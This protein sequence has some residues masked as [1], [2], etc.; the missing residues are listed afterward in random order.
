MDKDR[1]SS[2]PT[3]SPFR[4]RLTGKL[5]AIVGIVVIAPIIFFVSDS[6]PS[7]MGFDAPALRQIEQCPLAV[8][9]LGAP[10]SRS[11]LGFSCGN[12]KEN[13]SSGH[14]NWTFPVTGPRGHGSLDVSAVQ[15]GGSWTLRRAMLETDRGTIDVL[16]CSGGGPLNVQPARFHARVTSTLG[17]PQVAVGDSCDVSIEAAP[18]GGVQNCRVR[19]DCGG[20]FLYGSGTSGYARCNAD[21]SGAVVARDDQPTSSGGDPTLDLQVARHEAIVTDQTSSGTWVVQ[22]SLEDAQP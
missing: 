19:I 17:Q 18:P 22:L 7:C 14:A 8:E 3:A 9:A 13:G 21:Q 1:L 20:R 2:P 5:A 6:V 10:V 11:W 12:A 15:R 16:T 4:S